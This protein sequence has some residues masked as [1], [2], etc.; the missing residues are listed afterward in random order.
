MKRRY[1]WPLLGLA[2]LL[3]VLLA[4]HLALPWLV[5]DYLNEKLA[6]MGDYRGQIADVDLA[7]WRGA[8][9]INGLQIVKTRG[10]VPVPL[11][12]APLIDLSVSWYALWY[13]RAVVAEVEF[14]RPELNFV[15][16]G[17]Q[18]ASQTGQGTNWRQQ[19]EKLLP[20]TLD[21]VR[22]VDGT[23]SF[24]NFN[25]KPP[26]D[27]QAT[28]LNASI[29]N[30]TNVVDKQGRRDA[31]FAGKALL[32]GD[33]PVEST[34]TFDPLSDFE[35]FQ[36]RLRATDLQLR[37]LN[38]FASAYG[39]FDFKAGHGDLVIEA[40]AVKGRLSGYIKP[41]LR[42][43]EVFDWQQDV[44]NKD[45]TIF[46]SIWE[47]LVGATETVLKNQPKNQFATRVELSGSVRQSDISAF[48]AFLQ[49][50]R[51]GFIE[52]FNARYE[53]SPPKSD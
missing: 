23:L 16:G 10:K 45:K 47:A 26:V 11:L 39:K 14:L 37:R 50:L 44:E 21:E 5:R 42:D 29:R 36:F 48:E 9:R 33:A 8:Y 4:V 25:S 22:I 27:L 28:R 17:S 13:E 1:R 53:R 46:R 52:A 49:I 32:P 31:S 18:Q 6:D 2:S 40:Q 30:L 35:D 38:A 51:N 3:A 34:A 19:L 41:L 12:Q 7:W 15:D 20:I 43:V 24:R